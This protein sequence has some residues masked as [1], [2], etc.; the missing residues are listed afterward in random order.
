MLDW[1]LFPFAFFKTFLHFSLASSFAFEKPKATPDPFHV[2][3]FSLSAVWSLFSGHPGPLHSEDL[4]LSMLG[5]VMGLFS[6]VICTFPF[7]SLS[8]SPELL[9]LELWASHIYPVIFLNFFLLFPIHLSHR[10]RLQ[11]AVSIRSFP[12]CATLH[13]HAA[14]PTP[15]GVLQPEVRFTFPAG[16][17]SGL[18]PGLGGAVKRLKSVW[19]EIVLN[20][21]LPAFIIHPIIL[22]PERQIFQTLS[23]FLRYKLVWFL[24]L[25][26][27]F[28]IRLS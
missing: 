25:Q 8:L 20:R 23:K 22:F 10:P 3:C 2:A 21:F 15:S 12:F 4:C 26:L 17:R 16:K 19:K 9:L 18:L 14:S 11:K 28:S 7:F 5:T 1:S 24:V 13:Q 27:R 6:L